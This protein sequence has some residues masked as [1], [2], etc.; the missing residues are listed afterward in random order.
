MALIIH[1]VLGNLLILVFKI[2]S[3]FFCFFVFF[4]F[5]F[6][7]TQFGPNTSYVNLAIYVLRK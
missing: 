4:F 5:I 2:P 6:L 7:K 3:E 1:L